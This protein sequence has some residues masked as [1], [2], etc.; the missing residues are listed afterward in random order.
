MSLKNS[1]TPES[2][3]LKLDPLKIMATVTVGSF[4][5]LSDSH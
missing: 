3:R 2:K 1:G 5:L 4:I